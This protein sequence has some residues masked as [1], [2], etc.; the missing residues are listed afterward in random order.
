MR[1]DLFEDLWT[2]AFVTFVAVLALPFYLGYVHAHLDTLF[3]YA[4]V[5]GAGLA[6]GERLVYSYCK[7]DSLADFAFNAG[8]RAIAVLI[9]G[10]AAFGLALWLV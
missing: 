7:G 9:W 6:L 8:L 1:L 2:D 4:V 5:A 10:G 3:E